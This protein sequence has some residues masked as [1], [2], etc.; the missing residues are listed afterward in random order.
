[1]G[2]FM[3]NVAFVVIATLSFSL[4]EGFFILPAHI[5]HSKDLQHGNKKG[6]LER[7]TTAAFEFLKNRMYA[8][9]LRF[10]LKNK[11][12][13]VATAIVTLALSINL[14]IGGIV[15]VTFFPNVDP[16]NI[17]VALKLPAGTTE[18]VTNDYLTRIEKAAWELNT[19]LSAERNDGQKIVESIARSISNNPSE[20]SLF[21]SLLDGETRNMLSTEISNQLSNNVG[22][23]HDAESLT[24]GQK[25]M[26]GAAIQVGFVGDDLDQLRKVKDEFKAILEADV[27]LKNVVDNDQKGGLE[28]QVKLLPKANALG[29]NLQMVIGQIRQ[30]YFGHEIQR[31][32][33]GTDEVKVWLR[34]TE[35]ERY[36]FSQL[37]NMKIKV[38]SNSYPLKE[39][40]S[41]TSKRG[42]LKISHVGGQAKMEVSASLNDA[43]AS[44]TEIYNN[45]KNIVIPE[46]LSRYD[47][48][49]VL[50]E[51]Q[52]ER[53]QETQTSLKRWLP[54]ILLLVF[55]TIVL[56]FRSFFQ[57]AVVLILIPFAFI[58]VVGGHWLHSTPISMLS[59]FGIL[60]VAG[61]VINDSLV[62]V[63][64]M[65]RLL[66][67]G[68]KFKEAVYE[69][70]MSRFRPIVLTSVTTV[71]GL[72]P[73]VMETSLQAQ[74]VIPMAISLA[75][76][77]LSATFI[78]L[79]VL[80]P[81]L[82]AINNIRRGWVWL[83]E[84][85]HATP[86]EVE[87]SVI[88]DAHD[89]EEEEYLDVVEKEIQHQE[90]VNTE[91][92]VDEKDSTEKKEDI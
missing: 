14:V 22:E 18:N 55:F 51:G 1:M 58:G 65:N 23:I 72:L 26:F 24:Y 19:K 91:N 79:L 81:L 67:E 28:F 86:E 40:A 89:D 9:I 42:L 21:I 73:I 52:S 57:A 17:V 46:I 29:I 16:D 30:G 64:T 48:V 33:R 3:S 88:E 47:G 84:G 62:L 56:N 34:Y 43:N 63:S 36:S 66:K 70:S 74:F 31:L 53:A 15:K 10:A 68:V 37:E 41:L 49:N 20:G 35:K 32:Q 6:M 2:D 25:T 27:R 59:M 61:V 5:A 92:N 4:I 71:A 45:A 90:E 69:A 85:K 83:W 76:G 38:G 80:P 13:A 11:M 60:A 78:M 39:L 77:L 87:P 44:A 12:I 7:S 75:Y 8:P 50:Y 54:I 82:M